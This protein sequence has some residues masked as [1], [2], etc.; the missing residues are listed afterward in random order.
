MPPG[1]DALVIMFSREQVRQRKLAHF[2][3]TFGPAALPEGSALAAMMGSFQ[4]LVDGWNDDPQEIYAIPE[5]RKFYQ[6]FHSV[7]RYWFYFCDLHTETL[8]MMTFCLLPR[9]KGFKRVGDRGS[10]RRAILEDAPQPLGRG[11]P[12]EDPSALFINRHLAEGFTQI[13]IVE[14][15]DIGQF[16][17]GGLE[18]G[19]GARV[20]GDEF[21]RW[22]VVTTL[23]DAHRHALLRHFRA[24]NPD[25]AQD[26]RVSACRGVFQESE[27]VA[28]RI[29]KDR[30]EDKAF[31]LLHQRITQCFG[32]S[33]GGVWFHVEFIGQHVRIDESQPGGLE[34]R[35]IK[36]SFACSIWASYCD[37]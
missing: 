35:A 17:H 4:F 18:I 1:K 14:N 20:T 6:H 13:I 9:L 12:F 22:H 36:R 32:H 3:K 21:V 7:W 11:F 15:P 23:G 27:L 10:L 33:C 31:S 5:I 25:E 28:C 26:H 24:G 2:L 30:F 37:D 8:Q 19:K 29:G 16:A 34:V